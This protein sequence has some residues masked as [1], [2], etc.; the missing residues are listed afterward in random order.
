[1][2]ACARSRRVSH[3]VIKV[4]VVYPQIHRFAAAMTC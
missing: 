3:F 4:R 2:T 1:M